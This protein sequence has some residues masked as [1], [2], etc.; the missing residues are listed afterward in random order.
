[1]GAEREKSRTHYE[2]DFTFPQE[3]LQEAYGITL[4]SDILKKRR[5]VQG[6]TID[7]PQSFD[8][9]DAVWIEQEGSTYVLH[10]SISDVA[11]FVKPD[12]ETDKE[13]MR[14]RTTRY[15]ESSVD[16]PMLP[17][18][19][20]EN[21]LSLLPGRKRATITISVPITADFKTGVPELSKTVFVSGQRLSYDDLTGLCRN[22]NGFGKKLREYPFLSQQI[23]TARGINQDL[24]SEEFKYYK[25]KLAGFMITANKEVAKFFQLAGVPLI[26]RNH[27]V[28]GNGSGPERAYYSPICLGHE[29]L[30]LPYYAR[31]TSP[32]RRYVDLVNQRQMLAFI[33][34]ANL[35]YSFDD[36]FV[37][38]EYLNFNEDR[39]KVK[40]GKNGKSLAKK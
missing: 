30:N 38:S 35:P 15:T 36:L 9:D 7:P 31:I 37:V 33:E 19:L 29:G 1:M 2:K 4:N 5:K 3:V 23:M 11:S 13:A 22:E 32:L 40:N 18:V 17:P 6:F 26:F 39:D 14:R 10:V 16:S 25:S 20:S 8:L 21:L 24:D 12:T 34:K 28:N 27:Q